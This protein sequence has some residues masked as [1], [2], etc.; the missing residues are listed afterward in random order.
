MML[1]DYFDNFLVNFD[2]F[3]DYYTEFLFTFYG[4]LI[5]TI[6]IGEMFSFILKTN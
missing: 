3:F 5:D 6:P 2:I 1:C 4:M